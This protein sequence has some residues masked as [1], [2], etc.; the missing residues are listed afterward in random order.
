MLTVLASLPFVAGLAA[1]V[2]LTARMLKDEGV[3]IRAALAG[4]SLLAEPVMTT[5][6]VKVRIVSRSRVSRPLRS[7]PLLRAAA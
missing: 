2:V 4:H 3:K 6:P 1:A 7:T 5:R